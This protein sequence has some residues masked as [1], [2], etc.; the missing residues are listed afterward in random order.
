MPPHVRGARPGFVR[1][2]K[3]HP[4]L[5]AGVPDGRLSGPVGLRHGLAAG[6]V[7]VAGC[8]RRGADALARPE[9]SGP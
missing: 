7:R 4:A 5:G 3:Q 1:S 6:P 2:Q 9:G 8:E